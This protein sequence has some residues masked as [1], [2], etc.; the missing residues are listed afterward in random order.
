MTQM[1]VS[2]LDHE[3]VAS[4][5]LMDS[6]EE[7]SWKEARQ[8][9]LDDYEKF[10]RAFWD[11]VPGAQPIRWN[12]HMSLICKELQTVAERVFRGEPSPYDL[13]I[14]CPP[15]SSKSTL[16]TI[17]FHAWTWARF[18]QARHLTAS[19]TS[20]LVLD[21]ASKARD[22][23]RSDKYQMYF[24]N[25]EIRE[26]HEAKGLYR[27]N[28]GGDRFACTVA[29]KSPT[30]FHAH[31]LIVDDPI[32]PK[33]SVSAAELKIASDFMTTVLPSRKADKKT[34][35]MI[36]VM[37]RLHRGDPSAVI[38]ENARKD[39]AKPIRHICLPAELT[40]K[41]SPVELREFY[42]EGY[43]D[44]YRLSEVE[45]KPERIH[46]M[47]YSSQFL[48]DPSL[49]EGAMFRSEWF[50]QICKAAPY[51]C[52]RVRSWDRA[53]T[54]DGGCYTAGVLMAMDKEGRIYVE[55]CVHG[56]W[57][58]DERNRRMRE[59][60]IKDRNR[61]GRYEPRIITER[62]GGSS[63][64]DA[65]LMICRVLD[66][67]SVGEDLPT[68]S[69]DTRAEPWA[70][71][72]SAGNV[73]FVDD[74]DW[75][76]KGYIEEHLSFAPEGVGKRLGKWKDRVDASS[77]CHKWISQRKKPGSLRMYPMGKKKQREIE[78]LAFDKEEHLI[79]DVPHW[80]VDVFNPW[81]EVTEAEV[82]PHRT[83]RTVLKIADLDPRNCQETWD[84]PQEVLNGSKPKDVVFTRDEAKKLWM[85]L[86][87]PGEK[88]PDVLCIR[89][90]GA[91]RANAICSALALVLRLEWKP[92]PG[93]VL[94]QHIVDTVK[95]SRTMV[96]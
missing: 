14:N 54:A 77:A 89:D 32:D 82:N 65:F 93:V 58:T 25:I 34:A 61:Y 50:Q 63:G 11:E 8:E 10:V 45:L 31:F 90:S 5:F 24:P 44:P 42:T 68:G 84:V 60:A 43:L 92:E 37:Q 16:I 86:L 19:H 66:G 39:G 2:H 1:V 28:Y 29:G 18:P 9:F 15:G 87:K 40:D 53:A 72:L 67:F 85:F 27:N 91:K 51:D 47:A 48:Q 96:L 4:P 52:V 79:M 73:W 20:E 23:I 71:Q 94:N 49:A 76:L 21:L 36:L 41:V 64:K 78:L 74:G 13:V 70:T 46:R 57:A 3:E 62:E 26:D 59:T 33:K 81:E 6:K 30:G 83:R 22:V 56:Q 35:V 7:E 55:D 38:L 12:W 80:I 75:D 17:L 88:P 69:K 95:A